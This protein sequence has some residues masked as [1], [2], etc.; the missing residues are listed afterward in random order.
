MRV[1]LAAQR[2]E[3]RHPAIPRLTRVRVARLLRQQ[4]LGLVG[5]HQQH[6]HRLGAARGALRGVE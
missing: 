4:H 5:I 2:V 6:S 1:E 3:H